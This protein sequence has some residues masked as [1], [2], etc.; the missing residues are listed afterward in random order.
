[1]GGSEFIEKVQRHLTDQQEDIQIQKFQKRAKP[2]LSSHYE[3]HALNK[4]EAIVSV[5]SSGGY[6]Y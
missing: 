3:S 5:Y 1:M 6:S 4:D 2:K